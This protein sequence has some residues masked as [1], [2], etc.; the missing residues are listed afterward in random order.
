MRLEDQAAKLTVEKINGEQVAV[1]KIPSF[2]L[3]LT[4][5]VKKLITEMKQ[6]KVGALIIDLRE[7]GGGALTEAVDLSG[8]FITDGPIVQVRDAYQRIR[9]HEDTE[10]EQVY[11]GH[12]L[13]MIDRFSASASEILQQLC[14]ITIEELLLVKILLVKE[15]FNK[16][17]H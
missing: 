3:G 2:Y 12:L 4:E 15:L 10:T 11:S 17:A 14:K 5:D 9:V 13:V 6:K 8:L 16:V 7:N 1:I